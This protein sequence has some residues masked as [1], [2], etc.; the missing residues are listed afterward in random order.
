MVTHDQG[1]KVKKP[2]S[3]RIVRW[4]RDG[5]NS[6]SQLIAPEHIVSSNGN[7]NFNRKQLK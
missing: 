6:A 2:C 3:P 5:R 4:T 1:V 7:S